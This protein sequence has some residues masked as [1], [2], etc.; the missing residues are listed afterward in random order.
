MEFDYLPITDAREVQAFLA[1]VPLVVERERFTRF[2]LGF[3]HHYLKATPPVEVLR[4]FGLV[5]ALGGRVTATSLAQ[6]GALWKLVVVAADRSF[7]F[8]RIAGSLSFFGANIVAAEAF[9][10][11]EAVVLD[12]FT[13]ADAT[14]RFREPGEGRR[15]Q[16]FLERVIEGRVDLEHELAA[17]SA[18]PC[19]TLDLKWDDEAHPTATQLNV[20]GS[21][22]F[23]LLHAITRRLSDAGCSIEIAHI[24]TRDGRIQ[25]TFYL[26]AGGG[27]LVAPAR[28]AVEQALGGLAT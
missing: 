6:E 25:D 13:V 26:T 24:D 15:F 28:K 9:G 7:L 23:G 3:P 14:G 4:H 10:N 20:C 18:P 1:K 21:D 11:T 5:S 19:V 8:S 22:A 12:T 17:H 2:V 16:A 27:K